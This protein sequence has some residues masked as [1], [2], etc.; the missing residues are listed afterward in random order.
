MIRPATLDDLDRHEEALAA[1]DR[2]LELDPDV[3]AAFGERFGNA[4]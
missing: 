3:A 1:C 2:A 4:A